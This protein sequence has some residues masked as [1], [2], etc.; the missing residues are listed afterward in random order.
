MVKDK[1]F[2]GVQLQNQKLDIKRLTSLQSI[3]AAKSITESSPLKTQLL[4]RSRLSPSFPKATVAEPSLRTAAERRM[5]SFFAINQLSDELAQVTIRTPNI[6]NI[7]PNK[8]PQNH[9]GPKMPKYDAAE[10]FVDLGTSIEEL[11]ERE[12][13]A[14]GVGSAVAMKV[15]ENENG[16]QN[17]KAKSQSPR[18]HVQSVLQEAFQMQNSAQPCDEGKSSRPRSQVNY[19]EARV[20]IKCA[21][22]SIIEII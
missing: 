8:S 19:K 15:T 21:L 22:V 18:N 11:Q 17:G 2:F 6:E 9:D 16:R 4:E 3:Q 13:A 5:S 10:N 14:S 12:C 7:E 20:Y 1:N